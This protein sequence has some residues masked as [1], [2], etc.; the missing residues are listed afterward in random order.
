M[1][2]LER[3]LDEHAIS[4][5]ARAMV[6]R[7]EISKGYMISRRGGIAR[8]ERWEAVPPIVDNP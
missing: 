3:H 6:M 2:R 7:G 5:K 4:V 1:G 8:T